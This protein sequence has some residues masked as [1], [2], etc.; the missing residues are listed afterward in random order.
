MNILANMIREYWSKITAGIYVTPEGQVKAEKIRKFVPFVEKLGFTPAQVALAWV[1][2]QPNVSTVILGATKL[3]Q[4]KDNL[5]S[6]DVADKLAPDNLD[7]IEGISQTKP[8]LEFN[9]R[10]INPK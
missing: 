6:L 8:V 4:L 9:F 10:E 3:D 1:L 5:K 2:K 7:E